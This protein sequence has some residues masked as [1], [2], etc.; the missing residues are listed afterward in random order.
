LFDATALHGVE[1]IDEG[2]ISY[3]SLVFT[4]RE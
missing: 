1:Q 4:L 2:P 3:L